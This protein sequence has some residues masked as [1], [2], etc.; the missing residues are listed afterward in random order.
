MAIPFLQIG[1]EAIF[2]SFIRNIHQNANLR[3][4]FLNFN[5]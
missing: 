4:L 2:N 5:N 3:I 1:S